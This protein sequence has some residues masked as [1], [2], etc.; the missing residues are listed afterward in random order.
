MLEQQ[1]RAEAAEASRPASNSEPQSA[2]KVNPVS[3]NPFQ[4]AIRTQAR[5]RMGLDG[6][7]GSGKTYT[8][9]VAATALANGGRI[10]VIDTERNSA[11]LYSDR[12]SF[13]VV[14]LDT[15]HP[16]KYIDMIH[17]AE[18]SGYTVIVIDSLSHAWE[19]EGG[20]LDLH[21]Q[22]VKRQRTENSFT[23][24]KDVTP[25]HRALVDAM[26]Q[27]KCH[28][29]AT[30][31]S[32]TEYVIEAVERNG[33][34]S[35]QPKKVG[36]APVQRQGMEYE[37]TIVGDLDVDHNLVI[38]KSRM[39]ALADQVMTKP[40]VKFFQ[41]VSDWLNSGVPATTKPVVEVAKT[42]GTPRP[43]PP[44]ILK[45]KL[46]ARAQSYDGKPATV[47]QRNLVAMILSE[48]FAGPDSELQRHALQNYLFGVSSL[49]DLSSSLILVI[50]NDWLKPAIDSGGAY[51]ADYIAVQE[52]Q[53]A[54][55]EAVRVQGQ[56]ALPIEGSASQI[57]IPF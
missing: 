12:F 31:R 13:D 11:S 51:H 37:F 33:R 55:L 36:M 41:K 45:A 7:S 9:L 44:E 4:K 32:K 49:K 47:K 48:I 54:Y 50:L 6:P 52:A 29:I 20:V 56:M 14:G 42:N 10:A 19:G 22:A 25:I 38:S 28:I 17:V 24:W 57:E 30:M 34:V 35:Q 53:T 21:D 43:Y 2:Q 8:A 16:Q 46:L 26:L 39:E 5:L 15:F 40:D 3:N 18:E 1:D 27:S 23:A